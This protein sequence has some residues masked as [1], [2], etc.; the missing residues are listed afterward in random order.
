M[1]EAEFAD[2]DGKQSVTAILRGLES[3]T[4]YHYQAVAENIINEEGKEPGLGGDKT[5]TTGGC[6]ELIGEGTAIFKFY[7]SPNWSE[8]VPRWE[9]AGG[10]FDPLEDRSQ[11]G[12]H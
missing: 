2:A 7:V 5:F 3:C 10:T 12:G 4:T 8:P 1:T 6:E 9:R 11:G